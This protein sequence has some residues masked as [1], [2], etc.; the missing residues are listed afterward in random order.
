V[1]D[2]LHALLQ[3]HLIVATRLEAPP[4]TGVAGG[5]AAVELS[6]LDAA[7]GMQL[8]GSHLGAG[9]HWAGAD[10]EA[11]M[12]LVDEVQGN[13]LVRRVAVGLMM[14]GRDFTWQLPPAVVFVSSLCLNTFC[15]TNL[16]IVGFCCKNFSYGV[17]LCCVLCE[18]VRQLDACQLPSSFNQVRQIV[19]SSHH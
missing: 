1:L 4:V 14:H 17:H 10:Q 11:A 18:L 16:T 8:L 12:K 5:D 2:C 15:V 19:Y 3:V 6:R 9:H 7:A 13:P